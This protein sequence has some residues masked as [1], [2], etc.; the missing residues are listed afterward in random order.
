MNSPFAFFRWEALFQDWRVFAGG[1]VVTLLISL[2]A[3]ALA[4]SVG[5]VF[6]LFSASHSMV[7]RGIVRVFV[8]IYQNTPLV[9]QLFFL[10]NGLPYMG[11]V[12]PVFA[13]GVLG[14]GLYHGA[15]ISEVVRAGIAA[16]PSGQ[17]EASMSQGFTYGQSMRHIVLPQAVRMILP[18]LAN[19]A[20]NLIKNTS[21]LAMIAGGELMY[22]ADS[23]AGMYLHYGP[24]YI[25]TGIL[26]F[27]LTFPLASLARNMEK[28]IK[29]Q[30]NQQ[31][32][33]LELEMEV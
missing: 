24:A 12:L 25:V 13:I 14:V 15:Y 11:I 5:V 2:L 32:A 26:Y 8:E 19:Q 10:Y 7:L 16:V 20:V 6:G 31:P 30:G 21:V 27:C 33:P 28:S 1:F 4:L 23:W 22:N 3:L 17:L 29:A 18:S 9:I